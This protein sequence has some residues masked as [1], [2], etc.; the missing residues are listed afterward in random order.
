M[1]LLDHRSSITYDDTHARVNKERVLRVVELGDIAPDDA[2]DDSTDCLCHI[3][4][5]EQVFCAVYFI[6]ARFDYQDSVSDNVDHSLGKVG[7]SDE[8]S[9]NYGVLVIRLT[10]NHDQRTELC[11]TH[12]YQV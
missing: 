7:Q 3:H 11:Q 10:V 8:Q 6:L 9:E 1:G 4:Q 2:A 12:N 5:T